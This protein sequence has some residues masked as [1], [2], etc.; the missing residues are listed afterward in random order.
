ML[1]LQITTQK[2]EETVDETSKEYL[3]DVRVDPS[4][5]YLHIK[6]DVVCIGLFLFALSTRLV[7][8]EEPNYIV[9]VI[10]NLITIK[11]ISLFYFH[12]N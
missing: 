12:P 3:V 2:N 9:S 8:L 11:L 5:F 7:N 1:L 10:Y 4:G 6:I